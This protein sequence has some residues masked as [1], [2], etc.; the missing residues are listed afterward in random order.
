M[1]DI[2]KKL[3]LALGVFA[4]EYPSKLQVGI[5]GACPAGL[6]TAAELELKGKRTVNLEKQ[7]AVGRNA[8]QFIKRAFS[9]CEIVAYN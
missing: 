6:T 9:S 7:D 2:I 8:K 3:I 5:V 4:L 1:K